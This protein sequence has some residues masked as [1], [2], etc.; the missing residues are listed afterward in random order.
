MKRG[1]TSAEK[2]LLP[3][4]GVIKITKAGEFSMKA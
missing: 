4:C 1:F 2:E 3:F